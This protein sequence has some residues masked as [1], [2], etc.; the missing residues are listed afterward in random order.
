MS[1]PSSQVTVDSF[2]LPPV[3]V[4]RLQV[5]QRSTLTCEFTGH[6]WIYRP[7]LNSTIEVVFDYPPLVDLHN[8]LRYDRIQ[9]LILVFINISCP[10]IILVLVWGM[11][12][13]AA[14]HD[15]NLHPHYTT[16]TFLILYC[17]SWGRPTWK[18]INMNQM[19]TAREE[20]YWN[21]PP[22]APCSFLYITIKHDWWDIS[23]IY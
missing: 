5:L 11:S 15:C 8:I 16:R 10:T 13:T 9:S 19:W 3:E 22:L 14:S 6:I 18:M 12:N 7:Y 20:C 21:H 2:F 23:Y 4:R 1:H 17:S